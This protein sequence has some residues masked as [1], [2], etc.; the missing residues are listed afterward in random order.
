MMFGRGFYSGHGMEYGFDHMGAY[1]IWHYGMMAALI[2]GAIILVFWLVKRNK[3]PNEDAALSILRERYAKGEINEE[4]F[5]NKL[6][7]LKSK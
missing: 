1:G 2:I 5:T 4:E 7:I 6:N 3:K